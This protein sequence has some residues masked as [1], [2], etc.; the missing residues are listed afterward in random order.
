M[1]IAISNM[2]DDDAKEKAEEEEYGRTELLSV[3]PF[4]LEN[5]SKQKIRYMAEFDVEKWVKEL[6][7][8]T[9][10]TVIAPFTWEEGKAVKHFY[11]DGCCNHRGAI[12]AED[13][14]VVEHLRNR[15]QSL[16]DEL[17]PQSP[18]HAFFVRFGPRSPKDA[19]I[20]LTSP[21][22]VT[23][24]RVEEVMENMESKDPSNVY[25]VLHHF[26]SVCSLLLCA[27]SVDDAMSLLLSSSRVMQDICHTMDHGK[28]GWDVN[29][30]VRAWDSRVTLEREFRAF[31]ADGVLTAVAQYDDQMSYDFVVS[32]GQM[33][34]T[35][36]LSCFEHV[37]PV[38]A[39]LG[40]VT[41]VV[42][43]VV[44]PRSNDTTEA[45]GWQACVIEINPFGRMTGTPLFCFN[46]D[47]RLLQGGKDLYGDLHEW[48]E[49]FPPGC[50]PLPN[51]VQE[52]VIDGV[53]F[54]F[55]AQHPPGYTWDK[56]EAY[57]EDYLR[58]APKKLASRYRQM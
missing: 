28:T 40:Y 57:W 30:V 21:W 45:G 33:I 39:A 53:V 7:G 3:N 10:P 58:L 51:Y 12:T 13:K 15:I 54:R 52:L 8:L 41:A 26:Q 22:G 31:V 35:N 1:S 11:Q 23:S 49:K 20:F 4:T 47:R 34:I 5:F 56:L 48:E 25:E 50:I 32:N 43:F 17:M 6:E 29:L 38:L 9:F 37:K 42:D 46:A 44:M 19:P 14:S 27:T 18:E 55:C 16:F 2:S 24:E 36:I